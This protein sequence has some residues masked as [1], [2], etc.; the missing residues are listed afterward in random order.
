MADDIGVFVSGDRALAQRF[1]DF[2]ESLRGR[3]RDAITEE[4]NQLR[5]RIEALVPRRT[6]RLA[7]EI[8]SGV[9]DDPDRVTGRVT[10]SGEYAKAG[11][12]EYGGKNK[13]FKV[14]SHQMRLDH[15]WA[16]AT[17]TPLIV[18][19]PQYTRSIHTPALRFMRGPLEEMRGEV[20]EALHAAVTE[21]V[22]P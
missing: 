8:V 2:P 15:L 12:L 3:L 20:M 17:A 22:A 19:V 13:P 18:D 11:A 6:G 16:R 1:D 21:A 9:F 7:S 5:S 14:L 10:V 4:T